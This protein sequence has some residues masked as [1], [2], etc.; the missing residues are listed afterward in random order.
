MNADRRKLLSRVAGLLSRAHTEIEEARD[1]EQGAYD[2][3]P[4]SLQNGA[5]GDAMQQAIDAM[6]TALDSCDAGIS[7]LCEIEGVDI[8]H[9]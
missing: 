6:E 4:E 8:D 9:D 7:A 3:L 1:A 2:N 5:R